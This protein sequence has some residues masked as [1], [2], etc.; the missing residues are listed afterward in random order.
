MASLGIATTADGRTALIV[1]ENEERPKRRRE[2]ISGDV[3]L[4]RAQ[5]MRSLEELLQA[6]EVL[7]AVL[8][9]PAPEIEEAALSDLIGGW[10]ANA[11]K[12]M[13]SNR[14]RA[15]TND[16]LDEAYAF[17]AAYT[18]EDVDA[19]IE[20]AERVLDDPTATNVSWVSF[21]EAEVRAAEEYLG[22]SPI[23]LGEEHDPAEGRATFGG[24]PSLSL[25]SLQIGFDKGAFGGP[26]PLAERRDG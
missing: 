3:L 19:V 20:R 6:H 23:T 17:L 1:T 10:R 7:Y 11:R 21:I 5:D 12:G 26:L 4:T 15:M 18:S 22:H 25:A 13:A 14:D 2:E 24:E 16:P 9:A 8:E